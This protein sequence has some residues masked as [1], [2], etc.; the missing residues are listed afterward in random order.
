MNEPVCTGPM[1]WQEGD[2]DAIPCPQPD[3]RLIL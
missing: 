2:L 3:D 1:E